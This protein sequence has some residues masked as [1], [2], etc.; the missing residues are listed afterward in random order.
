M[1]RLTVI[2]VNNTTDELILLAWCFD[3]KVHSGV[4]SGAH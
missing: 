3:K 2:A 1:E 4:G